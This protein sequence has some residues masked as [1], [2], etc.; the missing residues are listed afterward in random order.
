MD[1]N[2]MPLRITITLS[3]YEGRKLI[4]PSKIHGKPK[5]TYAA[6]IIGSRIEANF[7]EINRQMADIAKREGITVAELEARWLAEE[8]FELD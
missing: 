4:C 2:D 3:A 7:E 5:A 8:N 1:D 6:Q